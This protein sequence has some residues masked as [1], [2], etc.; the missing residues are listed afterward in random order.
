MSINRGEKPHHVFDRYFGRNKFNQYFYVR[1]ALIEHVDDDKYEMTVTWLTKN[2]PRDKIPIS[3]PYA[4]P[5]GMIGMLPERG[6][7]GIFAFYDE[8]EGKG[9]PLCVGFLPAGLNAGLNFNVVKNLP[10]SLPT[11]DVNEVLFK[12]RKLSKDDIILASPAFGEFFLN[13]NVEIHDAA[14]DSIYIRDYD[15]SITL[16]SLDYHVFADGA[17][18]NAGRVLRNYLEVFDANGAKKDN[19][20]SLMSLP[21]GDERVYITRHGDEEIVY[22]TEFF[23]EYRIDVDEYGDGKLDL[24]EINSAS[25][26]STR[27][28]IVTFA[29]GNYVGADRL[30]PQQYGMNLKAI[31]FDNQGAPNFS[32]DKAMTRNGVDEPSTLGLAYALHFLKTNCFL[33]IDKEGHY[34]QNLPASS[35]AN[36]LGAGTSMTTTARGSLKEVWGSDAANNNSWDLTTDGGVVWSLGSDGTAHNSL[37]LDIQ[38]ESGVSWEIKNATDDGYALREEFNGDVLQTVMGDSSTVASNLLLDINGLK[39]EKIGGSSSESVQ[40]DKSLN[41][42]GMYTE[43]V[44]K[45]KQGKYGT[46]KT[47]ITSGNDELEVVA[48]DITESITSVGNRITKLQKGDITQTISIGN[49]KTKL[50]KG[51]YEVDVLG[52]DVL[53]KTSVGSVEVS[54]N[55][56]KVKGN[57]SVEVDSRMVKLGSGALIGGVVSGLPGKVTHN[58]YV[59]GSPLKGSTKVSVG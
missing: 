32:L 20:G 55:S 33:G 54:A 11:T 45:E 19:N 5:A 29:L 1:A 50:L 28:P 58:D 46:R 27:D 2:A 48:G 42:T 51:N 38:T 56:V 26:T 17:S 35:S 47:T 6:S 7:I 37:S 14:Q 21:E 57:I 24:N 34:Y 52:G 25:G 12:F 44:I 10:D 53:I 9:N 31:M 18:V 15:Q 41:V 43:T 49:Y 8:G 13:N 16:T 59:T 22:G 36:S 39:T 23:S 40:S 3:F 30:S 4:G